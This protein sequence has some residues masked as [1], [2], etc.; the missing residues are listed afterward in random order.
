MLLVFSALIAGAVR[1]VEHSSTLPSVQVGG[2]VV[3]CPGV[4]M[5]FSGDG[6]DK[7]CDR[8]T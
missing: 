8:V 3:Q 6:K 7:V 1:Q 4:I 2:G 5:F